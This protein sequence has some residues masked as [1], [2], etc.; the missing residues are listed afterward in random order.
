MKSKNTHEFKAIKSKPL[1]KEKDTSENKM[2]ILTISRFI[3]SC[4][5]VLPQGFA[6]NVIGPPW[7]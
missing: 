1:S 6:T 4:H 5:K 3:V 7:Y 2:R